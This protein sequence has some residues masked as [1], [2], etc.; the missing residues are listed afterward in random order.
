MFEVID[1]LLGPL[2]KINTFKYALNAKYRKKMGASL[3]KEA[4]YIFLYQLLFYGVAVVL[5]ATFV[6]RE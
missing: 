3:G 1:T 4:N 5:I 2:F 6:L